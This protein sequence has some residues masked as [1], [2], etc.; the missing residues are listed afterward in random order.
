MFQIVTFDAGNGPVVGL[1]DGERYYDSATF[2]SASEILDQWPLA[3]EKLST[4]AQRMADRTPLENVRLLA[5]LPQPRNLY[6]TGAN[7]TDHIE[8]MGRV[9]N[10]KL[11]ANAK[12]EGHPPWFVPKSAASVVGPGAQVRVPPGVQRL[13]WEVELGVI[14]GRA[15]ASVPVEQALDYVA[16]YTVVNDLSARDRMARAYEAPESA[17]R[18]DWLRH[19]SFAGSCPMGPAIT[20]AVLVADVQNLGIKLW[21]NDELMQ[22][23]HTSRMIYSVADLVAGLS[24][25]VPLQ[26][27]DLIL[28]GTPSGVGSAHGRFLKPGDRVRQWIEQIGEFEFTIA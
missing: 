24:E 12:A 11:V 3:L 23:S 7:Y 17:L 19:K 2:S 21:V 8:E 9:L 18:L 10:V 20:P 14:I 28:S 1:R 5:P 26:P 27:G 16:G 15:G 25:Q 4:A 13:D 6:L 22:D